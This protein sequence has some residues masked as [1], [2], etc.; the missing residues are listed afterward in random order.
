MKPRLLIS[1][2]FLAVGLSVLSACSST[3]GISAIAQD[4][5]PADQWPGTGEQLEELDAQS[6]RWLTTNENAD[7]FVAT[8]QDQKSV[9]LFKF[10]KN[11][12][13]SNVGGC[14]AAGGS[15]VIV[16]ISA[17]GARMMLV[18]SEAETS[19]LEAAGWKKIHE[20]ILTF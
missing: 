19:A 13:T 17:P 16:D 18:R 12:D 2:P 7:Y 6:V 15:D 20:N 3:T 9:C 8:S 4:A 11:P 5:N 1:L 14:G 10:T